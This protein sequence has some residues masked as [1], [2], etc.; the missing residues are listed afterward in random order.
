MGAPQGPRAVVE[1]KQ[2]YFLDIHNQVRH[3]L[4]KKDANEFFNRQL[5]MK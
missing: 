4:L 1:S 3:G 2:G 5:G